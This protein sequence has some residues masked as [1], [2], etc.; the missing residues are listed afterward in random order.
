MPGITDPASIAYR[1]ESAI[2]ARGLDP[3][4]FYLEVVVPHKIHL[5]LSY[6]EQATLWS[7]LRIILQ[8]LGLGR[9][10]ERGLTSTARK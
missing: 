3:E 2:L 1:D 4:R 7:D 8:T 10:D 6:A 5:S 9:R